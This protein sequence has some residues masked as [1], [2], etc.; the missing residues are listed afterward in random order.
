MVLLG[1][2]HAESDVDRDSAQTPYCECEI[3]GG[4]S[5]LFVGSSPYR[6]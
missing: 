1:Q 4:C 2:Y 3:E 5:L 6:S